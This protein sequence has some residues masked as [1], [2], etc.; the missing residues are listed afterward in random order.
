MNKYF[1]VSFRFMRNA[2]IRDLKIP[3][4]TLGYF[5]AEV[6]QIGTMII[7]FDVIF[8]T[9]ASFGGW[10]YYQVL[11]MY[12]FARVIFDID[13]ALTRPGLR[14]LAKSLVRYGELDF[15]LV[16]PIDPMIHVAIHKPHIYKY[17]S[18]LFNAIIAVWCLGK[19][20]L[21]ITTASYIWFFVLGVSGLILYFCINLITLIP[22]FWFVKLFSLSSIAGKLSTIMRYPARIYSLPIKIVF[23]FLIPLL[24][25]TYLPV[26]TLLEKPNTLYIVYAIILTGVFMI[27]TRKFWKLGLKAYNSA[28][29]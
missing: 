16:K 20:G 11:F 18:A 9:S 3:G 10:A 26:A 4:V 13:Q 27:L 7:F 25:I 28:S 17:V 15:F 21:D 22:V 19:T 1:K 24:V 12:F 29:S 23:S 5:M 8:G 6:V 2:I 14:M